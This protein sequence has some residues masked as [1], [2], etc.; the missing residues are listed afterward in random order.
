ME[1]PEWEDCEAA[2]DERTATALQKFIY[3]HE[4]QTTDDEFREQLIAV[5]TASESTLARKLIEA[6]EAQRWT[7]I[8]FDTNKGLE[9]AL[10]VMR[11]TCK[12]LGV[13]VDD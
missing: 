4:P 8:N 5:I 12:K 13:D 3:N 9:I 10:E 2:C 6:V 11:D 1:L 7:N